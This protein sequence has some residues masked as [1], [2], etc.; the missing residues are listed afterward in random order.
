MNELAAALK[1]VQA[2]TFF[3]YFKSH[4]YHH[5]VE[6]P[7]FNDYHGYFGGLYEELWGAVDP[8][9]EHIRAIDQYAPISIEDM[10][11]AKTVKEDTS[12]VA[13]PKQMFLNLIDANNEV[14]DSLNKSYDLANYAKQNGLTNFIQDRLDIHAKHGWQLRSLSK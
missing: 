11:S 2:N 6:G 3:M 9:A 1:I 10:H 8:I 5:N 12:R 7:N 14:I 4:S 13:L